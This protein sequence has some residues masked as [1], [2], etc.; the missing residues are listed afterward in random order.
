MRATPRSCPAPSSIVPSSRIASSERRAENMIEASHPVR[1]EAVCR[2]RGSLA[3]LSTRP[4]P[5]PAPP[6]TAPH[7]LL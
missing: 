6:P 1:C 4:C 7:H 2:A 3:V 5:P